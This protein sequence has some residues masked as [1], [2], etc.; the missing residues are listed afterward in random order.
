MSKPTFF[1]YDLETSGLSSSSDRIMQFAGQRTNID[2][3]EIG[4]PFNIVVKLNNDTLPSPSAILTTKITPQFT[5]EN[6]VQENEL[7]KILS[8]EV[9]TPDTIILGFNS[10]RFDDKFIQ[11]LFWRNFYDPYEWQW[12]DGR[13]RWDMLDVVR[14]TRALRPEDINWPVTDEGKPTNRLELITK[15]NGIS[16]ES[17][18]DA[19]SDVTALIDVTRL[20]KNKQPKLFNYLLKMRDKREV[21]SLVNLEKP[22][23]FVYSSGKYGS[24]Y[25]FTT[26]AFPILPTRN[27]NILVY[28]LRYNLDELIENA[29]GEDN[30]N[31]KMISPIIKE[32]AFNRCPAV[33]PLSVLD[34]KNSWEKISLNKETIEKNLDSLKKHT[35]LLQK[36]KEEDQKR[37]PIKPGPDPESSL[38]SSFVP[39]ADKIRLTAVRESDADKLADF[40]P[41]FIDE[42]LPELL[43]HYKAKNFPTSLS[44]QETEKW[45]E[46][47]RNRLNHQAPIFLTELQKYQSDK[48][49]INDSNKAYLLEELHLWYESLSEV[50]Y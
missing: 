38:Y 44:K 15:L 43:L 49:I 42:R 14:M 45:E 39:D 3:E 24:N 20:I 11:H 35:K 8:T 22:V 12:R 2:L 23:P 40:H 16:H 25:N 27:G 30:L 46:Y 19:L 29:K 18:H 32:F 17:A 13:S 10:I 7:A 31:L 47:R 36:L 1:F 26:V 41:N 48:S 28:D 33:A 6:G 9:F 34:S 21:K 5:L 50:D 37:E 4:E